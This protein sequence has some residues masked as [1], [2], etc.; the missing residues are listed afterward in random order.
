[1]TVVDPSVFRQLLGRFATGVSVLTTVDARGAPVGMT[2]NSVASVSLSP[3]LVSVCVD[4]EA[5][6]LEPLLVAQ[7]F[8]LNILSE[9]QEDISR[10]FAASL[11]GPFAGVGYRVSE[12]GLALLDGAIAFIEC[13]REASHPAGDHHIVIGCVVGGTVREG[14][15]LI[16]YRGG[17]GSL[18]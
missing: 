9:R 5:A 11:S 3:P 4:R 8:A 6:I 1:M 7:H 16:F 2:A 13:S 15:P 18:G 12:Q 10:R 17:Y 14:R